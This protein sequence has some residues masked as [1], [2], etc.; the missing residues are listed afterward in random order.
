MN[1]RTSIEYHHSKNRHSL[2]SPRAILPIVFAKFKP[3]S[4]LDVGC[5]IGTWGKVA[6]EL[7]VGDLTGLDG[8]PIPSE[9]RLIPDEYFRVQDLTKNWNLGRQFDMVLCLEVAEH[10]E[11][12][13]S[14]RFIQNL[15]AH[16]NTILFSAACPG[17][18]GQHHVNC[19]WPVFWQERFNAEG[20][21]CEDELRW[22]IWDDSRVEP[23]YRQNI[24]IAVKNP[25][26][27]GREKR[28]RPVIHPEFLYGE[29]YL[30]DRH[31]RFS[32]ATAIED[33]GMTV[34][35]YLRTPVKGLGAK[36]VKRIWTPT[37]A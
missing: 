7:G 35:W 16:S 1:D 26:K 15:T 12:E 20:F 11:H 13:F 22:T 28:L 24:F 33:G 37:R 19:Q 18:A 17:Q 6:M 23:W 2:Q 30:T 14:V 36:L 8:V 10:L 3:S 32:S 34:G 4:L 29:K 9:K 25:E 21:Y 27:A 31:A 5:G